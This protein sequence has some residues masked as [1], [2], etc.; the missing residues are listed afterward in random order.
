MGALPY[1]L[2]HS[3]PYSLPPSSVGAQC[4]VLSA[5]GVGS[6]HGRRRPPKP[7]RPHVL[8]P[9]PPALLRPS[10]PMPGT[11]L[12]VAYAMSGTDMDVGV[13]G[14]RTGARTPQGT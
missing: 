1:S 11:R 5:G 7:Q 3:L 13:G 10:Y 12:W 9:G 6:G 4:G 2:P 8:P 14:R